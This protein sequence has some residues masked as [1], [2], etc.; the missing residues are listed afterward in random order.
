[1]DIMMSMRDRHETDGEQTD[2]ICN[3]T[4]RWRSSAVPVQLV[5][6]RVG[7]VSD[8]TCTK[9]KML[10]WDQQT[11]ADGEG[12]TPRSCTKHATARLH[13]RIRQRSTKSCNNYEPMVYLVVFLHWQATHRH[14]VLLTTIAEHATH[15]R[16]CV[17][18]QL[19]GFCTQAGF[20]NAHHLFIGGVVPSWHSIR[21][22]PLQQKV[23]LS[24]LSK[25]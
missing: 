10:T 9:R 2:K 22:T 15:G 17:Q 4:P 5:M 13:T 23:E 21:T 8:G 18:R 11:A 6:S 7:R 12:G 25:N 14:R 1:M 20:C 24:T 16:H 19:V 3:W